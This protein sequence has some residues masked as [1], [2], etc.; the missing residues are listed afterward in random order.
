M[1]GIIFAKSSALNN[2]LWKDT[3]LAIRSYMKDIDNEKNNDDALVN[4]LFN[5]QKSD[6]FG[7]K[8]GGVTE[9]ADFSIVNEG[10]K[11]VQD[12]IQAS[13]SKLIEH[14]Q[15]IKSFVCTAEMKEDGRINVMKDM[16]AQFVRAYKRSRA[17]QTTNFLCGEGATYTFGGKTLDRTVADGKALFATDH[18]GKRAGVPTQSNVFTDAFGSNATVLYKLANIGRNFRNASGNVMGYTFDTIVIPGNAPELEETVKRI[19]GSE[20]VVGSNNNDIN[21]QKGGWKLVVNHRWFADT[22]KKPYII[23]SSEAMKEL[24]GNLLYD[25]LP[26]S[27]MD[28]VDEGTWNLEW[29]G[30]YR[31]GVGSY[32]WQHAILGGAQAGSSL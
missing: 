29:S 22:E 31:L 3:D 23:M 5:V 24:N 27:V 30:R 17:Q 15:L 1:A 18:P 26:L 4:A 7:E 8:I 13:F 19:I 16:A 9:F 2:D 28:K 25:R 6:A 14:E 11:A 10:G 21:T 32:A 12:D 20:L